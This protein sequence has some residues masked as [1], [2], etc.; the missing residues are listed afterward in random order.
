MTLG[1]H[2]TLSKTFHLLFLLFFDGLGPNL[3]KVIDKL[4]VPTQLRAASDVAILLQ[5]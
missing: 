4:F 1:R 5:Y 3:H 2:S